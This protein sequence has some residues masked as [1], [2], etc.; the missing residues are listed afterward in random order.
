MPIIIEYKT[1]EEWLAHRREDVTSSDISVL[2]DESPYCTMLELYHR[3][4]NDLQIEFSDNERM[5]WGR[6]LEVP[7]ANGL[8]ED[9]KW[10]IRPLKVYMRHSSCPHYGSSFDFEIIRDGKKGLLELK[11]VDY[12][13]YKSKWITEDDEIEAPISIE[14]QAQSE[15][16][17]ANSDN[18]DPYEFIIIGALIG[19]NKPVIIERAVDKEIGKLM[20]DKVTKF[21]SDVA[22][23]IEP[24]PDFTRDT[25]IIK[26]LYADTSGSE[27]DLSGNN[28]F[29][30]LLAD[31]PA[32]QKAESEAKKA[33]DACKAEMTIIMGSSGL[34][35]CG[36][37][38][39]TRK[40]VK[41][42]AY[43]VD[44]TEYVDMRIRQPKGK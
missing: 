34:A 31:Y 24:S 37:T 42:G 28:R 33:K 25:D 16:E 5:K 43:S 41:R 44:A 38:Y 17:V 6:R 30:A 26:L 22:A 29:A 13:E 32:L 12:K 8:A 20:R 35:R 15:L 3:K 2:F 4:K 23:G 27:V 7:I 36:E 14:L 10:Q 39:V 19:G 9:N 40:T 18:P 21:W 1:E 11:T